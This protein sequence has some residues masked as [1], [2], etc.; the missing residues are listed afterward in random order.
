MRLQNGKYLFEHVVGV[1]EGTKVGKINEIFSELWNQSCE[2]F[3]ICPTEILLFL[4]IGQFAKIC[5]F[6]VKK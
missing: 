1:V 2:S 5:I 6:A 3:S 4:V